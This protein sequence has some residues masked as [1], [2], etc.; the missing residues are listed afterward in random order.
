MHPAHVAVSVVNL[1]CGAAAVL[2]FVLTPGRDLH[3]LF[4][5]AVVGGY[6]ANTLAVGI[7]A[8]LII[9]L[10]IRAARG[11]GRSFVAKQWL[12]LFNG[13]FVVAFWGALL[14]Y[15]KLVAS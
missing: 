2:L 9:V 10:L 4:A 15:G 11:Q 1:I 6:I 8:V 13:S 3:T 7:T 12:G 5:F 14:L